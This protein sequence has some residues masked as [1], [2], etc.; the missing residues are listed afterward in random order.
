MKLN[1]LEQSVFDEVRVLGPEAAED[2][3]LKV[4]CQPTVMLEASRENLIM[5]GMQAVLRM[6]NYLQWSRSNLSRI[7]V[8][9]KGDSTKV[10]NVDVNAQKFAEN[11]VLSFFQDHVVSGEEDYVGNEAAIDPNK[12]TWSFDSIDS[13][14]SFLSQE[15]TPAILASLFKNGKTVLSIVC[16]PFTGEMFYTF[17]DDNS[18]LITQSGFGFPPVA[19]ELPLIGANKSSFVNL[20]PNSQNHDILRILMAEKDRPGTWLGKTIQTGG[21]P[22]WNLAGVTKNASFAYIH[23]W[24]PSIAR[25]WELA[26]GVHVVRNTPGGIVTDFDGRDINALNHMGGMVATISRELHARLI[27]LINHG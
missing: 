21:S 1:E 8:T 23:K 2:D 10:T 18:R 14:N 15:N 25:P 16:N 4:E 27:E 13:T 22:G 19:H 5:V 17:N 3:L 11:F 7:A 26:A 12:Y 20:Q 24:G 9:T 6:A